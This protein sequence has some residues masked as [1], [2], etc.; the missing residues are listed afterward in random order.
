MSNVR[1]E[2]SCVGGQT[3]QTLYGSTAPRPRFD[4]YLEDDEA[5]FVAKLANVCLL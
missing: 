1:L 3:L 4:R 2:S 5:A